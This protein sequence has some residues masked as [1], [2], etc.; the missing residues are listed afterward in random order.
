VQGESAV[1]PG[2]AA[3]AA[4]GGGVQKSGREGSRKLNGVGREKV[5][6]QGAFQEGEDVTPS[7]CQCGLTPRYPCL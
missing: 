1:R 6:G 4:G 5:R 7:Q 3:I 2:A